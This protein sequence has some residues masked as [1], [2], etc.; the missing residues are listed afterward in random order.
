MQYLCQLDDIVPN[1]GVCALYKDKQIAVFRLAD[2][3]IFALDNYD[4]FSQANVLSRGI[5]G[6]LDNQVVVASPIHKQ[7]FNLESGQCL[8][9][10]KIK[11]TSYAVI[12]KEGAVYL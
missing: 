2:N 11:L 4:P 5:L 1:T 3:R 9:D 12:I 6:D 10:E 7:H 8:E